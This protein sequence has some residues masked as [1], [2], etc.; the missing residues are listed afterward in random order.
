MD[1]KEQQLRTEFAELEQQLQDPAI[2]SDK[3]YPKLAKRR[4]QLEAIV[5]L[6]D[7]RNRLTEARQQ[8]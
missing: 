1:H 4:S 6:F 3:S 8:A 7:E 5:G 2:F